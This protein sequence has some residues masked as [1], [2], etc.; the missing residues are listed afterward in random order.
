MRQ[1][2]SSA[3]LVAAALTFAGGVG[4]AEPATA[5]TTD[6]AATTSTGGTTTGTTATGTTTT[7][8]TTATAGTTCELA[9][10]DRAHTPSTSCTTTCHTPHDHR[11]GSVLD[12]V[13]TR[14]PE[15][16]RTSRDVPPAV[17]LV[18]GQVA[19]TSC[20]DGASTLTYHVALASDRPLCIACHLK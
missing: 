12:D 13:A 11:V 18:E 15:G 2:L 7:T 5:G 8:T 1:L 10:V 17:P 14:F 16:Y 20:H 3:V 4:A 6:P 19:C 9:S